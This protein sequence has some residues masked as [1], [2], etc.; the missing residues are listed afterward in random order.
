MAVFS[1]SQFAL[2]VV[3]RNV[4]GVGAIGSVHMAQRSE[5]S[6]FE[7][8]MSFISSII[9][10]TPHEWLLIGGDWNR[11][12]RTHGAAQSF[13]FRPGAWVAYM[14]N[15]VQLPKDFIVL[16]GLT[17]QSTGS[18][19]S[20]IGDHPVVRIKG[21]SSVQAGSTRSANRL[22]EPGRWSPHRNR[23]FQA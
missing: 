23:C 22:V 3:V 13:I 15:K 5:G 11:D 1:D 17:G 20:L 14:K 16:K 4:R 12:I 8:Q 7:A 21:V 2:L 6:K 9:S 18:S 10:A 19:L